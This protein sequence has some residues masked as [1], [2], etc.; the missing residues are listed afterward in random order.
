MTIGTVTEKKQPDNKYVEGDEV[1]RIKELRVRLSF[2]FQ[3]G[4]SNQNTKLTRAF[5]SDFLC[6]AVMYLSN[7]TVLFQ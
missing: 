7:R 4:D 3:V 1:I 2:E 5:K 6:C